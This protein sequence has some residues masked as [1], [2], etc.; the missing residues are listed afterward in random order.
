MG[1]NVNR[2]KPH[3]L[4]E[5][6]AGRGNPNEPSGLVS[7]LTPRRLVLASRRLSPPSPQGVAVNRVKPLTHVS[8]G[9]LF[10]LRGQGWMN[11][12]SGLT[13]FIWVYIPT[14]G[15]VTPNSGRAIILPVARP[16]LDIAAYDSL[17]TTLPSVAR[18]SLDIAAYDSL[19]T[20]LPP[21]ARP[22]RPKVPSLGQ[23]KR[24]PGLESVREHAPCRGKSIV[25]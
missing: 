7:K 18:P 20:T 23:A 17:R 11:G 15:L 8:Q 25:A 21:V 6:P 2:D 4:W 13:G 16:S 14:I 9:A 19:R 24:H 22:E 5:S 3:P 1:L 12:V 10:T